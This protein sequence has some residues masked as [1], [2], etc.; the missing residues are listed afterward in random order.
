MIRNLLIL[1]FVTA[2]LVLLRWLVRDTARAVLGALKRGGPGNRAA[3][4][5]GQAASSRLVK[6]PLSGTYLDERLAVKDVIDGKN[7]FFESKENRD[8]YRRQHR[9][10]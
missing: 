1:L 2:A 4:A 8:A 6:D 10:G 3:D 5:S 9:S 7:V